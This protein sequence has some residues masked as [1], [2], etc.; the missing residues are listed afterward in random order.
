MSDHTKYLEFTLEMI[1]KHGRVI[2]FKKV[3]DV[4]ADFDKPWKGT[5]LVPEL[6]VETKGCFVPFRGFEFG[7]N[8]IDEELFKR[9]DKTLLVAPVVDLSYAT[10]ITDNGVDYKIDWVREL[11]PAEIVLLYAFGITR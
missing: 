11:Q 10:I 1:N 3:S 8:V 6:V 9:S 2:Q 7:N 5:N 4:P